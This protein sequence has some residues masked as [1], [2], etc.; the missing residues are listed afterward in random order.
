MAPLSPDNTP[1]VFYTYQTAF[2]EHTLTVRLEDPSGVLA[3]ADAFV[4]DFLTAAGSAFY[5]ATITKVEQSSQ[6]SNVRFPVVSDRIGDSFGSGTGTAES[7]TYGLTFTGK[8]TAGRRARF[9]VFGC[10]QGFSNFKFT[11]SE[12]ALVAAALG[13]LAAATGAPA[14]IDGNLIVWN[15]YALVKPFDHWV[16]ELR[17]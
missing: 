11:S 2:N 17:G 6:G 7:D 15:S 4:G 3:D 16:D 5:P 12:N 9:T 10:N 13:V 1:R 8:S 14:A